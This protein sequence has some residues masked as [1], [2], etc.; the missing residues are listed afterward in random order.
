MAKANT[1]KARLYFFNVPPYLGVVGGYATPKQSKIRRSKLLQLKSGVNENLYT[2][3]LNDNT[4]CRGNRWDL[5][6]IKI[7]S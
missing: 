2:N 3:N 7:L 6:T 1:A 5:A 4:N